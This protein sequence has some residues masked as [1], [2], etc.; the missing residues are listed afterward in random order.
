MENTIYTSVRSMIIMLLIES[1]NVLH[2][3]NI[4]FVSA[5]LQVTKQVVKQKAVHMSVL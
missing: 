2:I 4:M 3:S 1:T 5:C